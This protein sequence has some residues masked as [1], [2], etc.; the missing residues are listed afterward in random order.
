M[1]RVFGEQMPAYD[2]MRRARKPLSTRNPPPSTRLAVVVTLSIDLLS[3]NES[4][5]S[6]CKVT[7][8]ATFWT[9]KLLLVHHRTHIFKEL[10]LIICT[11]SSPSSG[12]VHQRIAK[13]RF[14]FNYQPTLLFNV[15]VSHGWS[16]ALR[17][18]YF[19]ISN[20]WSIVKLGW[21]YRKETS[22]SS[23]REQLFFILFSQ[24][25]RANSFK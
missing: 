16:F 21:F 12:R 6:Q 19:W 15:A 17:W 11:V 18:Y 2:W 10:V 8:D 3:P 9:M 14:P 23:G 22:P 24:G 25:V 5:K 7:R 13:R 1:H 20:T 4:N